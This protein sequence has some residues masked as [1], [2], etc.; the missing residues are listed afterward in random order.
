M[1]TEVSTDTTQLSRQIK[2]GKTVGFEIYILL[3]L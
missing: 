2:N 1:V 3:L